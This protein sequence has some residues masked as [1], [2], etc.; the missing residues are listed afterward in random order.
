M[1]DKKESPLEPI[2]TAPPEVEK[3]IMRVLQLEKHRLY[4]RNPRFI[5][6]DIIAI[7]REEVK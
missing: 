4:E 1:D 2:K 7:I 5:N 6:A 3:I